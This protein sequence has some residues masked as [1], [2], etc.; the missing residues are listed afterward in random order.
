MPDLTEI[1]A[2]ATLREESVELCVDGALN[3]QF[4]ELQRELTD[5][6]AKAPTSLADGGAAAGIEA[7]MAKVR[8]DMA[9]RTFAFR[10]RALGAK[11]WSDLRAAHPGRDGKGEAWNLETFPPALIAAC[12]V[13][14]QLD[15]AGVERL[16]EVLNQ[17]QR[18]LL[19]QAAW[20]ANQGSDVPFWRAASEQMPS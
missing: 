17:G 10:F 5:A 18:D 12:C 15:A 9:E 4:E 6:L 19:F 7:Q 3:A 20:D 1:L 13:D 16:F 8:S 14:P 11:A 2:A